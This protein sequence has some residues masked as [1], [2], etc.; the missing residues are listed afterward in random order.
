MGR[1]MI[2]NVVMVGFLTAI[3]EVVTA[4]AA[5]KAIES[6]VPS[7]TVELN[8]NAFET[9]YEYGKKLLGGASQASSQLH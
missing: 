5:R 2:L 7:R 3:S 4:Q 8:I 6:T 1:R 9:G